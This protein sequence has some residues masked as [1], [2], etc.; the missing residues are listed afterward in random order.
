MRCS[1]TSRIGLAWGCHSSASI[2]SRPRDASGI[3]A[4][5]AAHRNC[6]QVCVGERFYPEVLEGDLLCF[7]VPQELVEPGDEQGFGVDGVDGDELL[8]GEAVDVGGALE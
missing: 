8:K 4:P 6:L 3:A 5:A 2:A 1:A 7:G